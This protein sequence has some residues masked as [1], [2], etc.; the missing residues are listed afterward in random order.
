MVDYKIIT[1]LFR[2]FKK[3]RMSRRGGGGG[4]LPVLFL[5]A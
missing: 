2:K 4:R 5:R 3:I 1:P